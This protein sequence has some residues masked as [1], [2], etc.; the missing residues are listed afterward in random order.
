MFDMR[1]REFVTLLSSAAAAW[2]ARGA[3][4]AG[5]ARRAAWIAGQPLHKLLGGPLFEPHAAG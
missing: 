2:A 1:R 4:A 5:R 3:R